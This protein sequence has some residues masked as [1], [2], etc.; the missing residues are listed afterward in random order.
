MDRLYFPLLLLFCLFLFPGCTPKVATLDD[1]PNCYSSV[2]GYFESETVWTGDTPSLFVATTGSD[3]KILKGTVTAVQEDGIV[4]DRERL[5][6]TFDPEPQLYPNE[7]IIAYVDSTGRVARGT[8]PSDEGSI[9]NMTL[10]VR[11]TANPDG[12]EKRIILE[13]NSRFG[14]CMPPGTYTVTDIHFEENKSGNV[15]RAVRYGTVQLTVSADSANYLGT[16]QLNTES[17][18]APSVYPIPVEPESRPQSAFVSG[19]LFGAIGSVVHDIA[20]EAQDIIGVHALSTQQNPDF[21]P[22]ASIPKNPSKLQITPNPKVVQQVDT[23]TTASST[24]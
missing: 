21:E 1:R 2:E 18:D 12:N 24:P 19:F 9:L 7:N 15:D 6:P 16:V 3:H 11:P 13:P 23:T 8:L 5:S 22:T 17:L 14:F 20:I 4:F 10:F